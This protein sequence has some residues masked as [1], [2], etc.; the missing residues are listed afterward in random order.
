MFGIQDVE[1]KPTCSPQD[2]PS[3]SQACNKAPYTYKNEP[4]VAALMSH[5][6]IDRCASDR[7]M[8]VA[9]VFYYQRANAQSVHACIPVHACLSGKINTR[10][11]LKSH[12]NSTF[13]HFNPRPRLLACLFGPPF[14]GVLVQGWRW[15]RTTLGRD[16][17]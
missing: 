14:V 10:E 2:D 7:Q 3:C 8:N 11:Q 4:K 6:K 17:S 1:Y 15:T 16:D 9:R 5:S 13:P 12:G